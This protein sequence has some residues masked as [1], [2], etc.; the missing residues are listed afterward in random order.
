[1][2]NV[3][4]IIGL[5]ML[6]ISSMSFAQFDPDGCIKLPNPIKD[7]I[8]TKIPK[9]ILSDPSMKLRSNE[10]VEYLTE[11]NN[12][13]A[14]YQ[15]AESVPQDLIDAVMHSQETAYL[16]LPKELINKSADFNELRSNITSALRTEKN[17]TV[18]ESLILI[19]YQT[20]IIENYG[21]DSRKGGWKCAFAIVAGTTVGGVLGGYL[22]GSVGAVYGAHA[23]NNLGY[24]LGC[25]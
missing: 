17:Q 3:L 19:H 16:E 4:K 15:N 5:F 7:I 8:K 23:G 6:L 25:K 2:K 22:G 12:S 9:D 13:Y 21:Y 10:M 24:H 18:V 14:K 20:Q 1:M 11:L